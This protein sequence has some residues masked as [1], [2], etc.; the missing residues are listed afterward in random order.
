MASPRADFTEEDKALIS[1]FVGLQ[2]G[3]GSENKVQVP[4]CATTS[5]AWEVALLLKVVTDRTVLDNPFMNTMR[6]AWGTDPNTLIRP[7]SK[8]L[9]LAEFISQEELLKV[10]LGGPWTYRGDLVAHRR[11]ATHSDLQPKHI[12]FANLWVQ[13]HNLPVNCLTEEGIDIVAS[14]LGTPVSPPVEGFV[15]G[16]RFFKVKV[17]VSLTKPLKDHVSFTHPTLGDIKVLCSYEKLTR[18]CRFCGALGHELAG[19]PDHQRLTVLS[20]DPNIQITITRGELL[21][22]KMGAWITNPILVPK[23]KVSGGG[24]VP[25]TQK[26]PYPQEGASA[27]EDHTGIGPLLGYRLNVRSSEEHTPGSN[28]VKRPRPAGL[29][30]PATDI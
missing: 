5:T 19:C 21:A 9:Y 22:P 17:M 20:Q 18:V 12:G 24:D 30:P 15:N 14:E 16:R 1:K 10:S 27:Q 25:M 2:T 26:R 23:E 29:I 11:V 6:Q 8:N 4:L 7:I 3:E 28:S 13:L